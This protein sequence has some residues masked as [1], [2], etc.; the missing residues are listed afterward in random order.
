MLGW[1]AVIMDSRL[2]KASV[3]LRHYGNSRG[4][5][6]HGT[7]A[8]ARVARRVEFNLVFVSCLNEWK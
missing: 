8:C 4:P 6:K 5:A 3:C 7:L 2:A 1:K